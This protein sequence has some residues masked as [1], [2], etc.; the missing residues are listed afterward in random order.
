MSVSPVPR[1]DAGP[2]RA[3]IAALLALCLTLLLPAAHA[4]DAPELKGPVT[5]TA[6][7][8]DWNNNQ[9]MEYRGNVKLTAEGFTL[10]GDQ[11]E[12]EQR[13][14]GV[15]IR[16]DGSPARMDQDDARIDGRV[17]ARADQLTYDA[18][19]QWIDLIG[20]ARLDR[21]KDH[22]EGQTIRY[23]VTARQ[24]QA[25]REGEGQQIRI[26]IDDSSLQRGKTKGDAPAP[27]NGNGNG[28]GDGDGDAAP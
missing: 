11:L 20:N 12:L 23:N 18:A 9:R 16:V 13:P 28:N 17:T 10:V 8:V 14:G 19:S 21:G 6:D 3:R 15:F 22:I 24:V 5:V 7:Q 1:T 27:A 4:A 25:R 26:V 2:A